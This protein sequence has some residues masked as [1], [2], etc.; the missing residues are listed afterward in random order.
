M[1]KTSSFIA[2]L[3]TI[4][5]LSS[6]FFGTKNVPIIIATPEKALL[7]EPIEI[8]ISNLAAHEQIALEASC[9]DKDNNLWKSS[10]IF[11]ADDKGMVHVAKQAP[12]SGSYK[13]IDPMGLFWSMA[14]TNKDPSKNT[15]ISQSTLSLHKIL[16]SIFSEDKLRA[17]KTIHRLPVSHDVEKKD[18]QEQGIVGTL[19]Y[20]KNTK[21]S[22]GLIIIPGSGGRAP[23]VISQL[24]ASHGYTVLALAYF[25]AEGLPERL[26]LIPLEY[27]QNA[28][29]WFKKQPQVNGNK[30]A[31]MGQSRGAELVLLLASTFPGEMDAVIAYSASHLVYSDF[32]S[33][34]KSAWT[35]KDTPVP[36]MP[37]P[38]N[39]E[40]FEAAKEGHIVLHKGTIEDPFQDTQIFLYA[41]KMKKFNKV[42]KEATIPVENIRCPILILSGDDDKMWPSPVSGNSIIERLDSKGSK[43]KRKHVNY[44]NTG[45]NLFIFPHVPS[46][47]LPVQITSGWSLFGGTP[48]GNAHAHKEAWREVLNFL[49][50]TL[51]K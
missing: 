5:L 43:I 13:S 19:F 22:P 16:L 48:D 49:N 34:Q 46:I 6:I 33:E 10:A 30:I 31:L 36:F 50:E 12:I 4:I 24:L 23:D 45:H 35:Y 39:K 2:L 44:P 26:S 7:D 27:F 3:S 21:R 51:Q 11:Q 28:M 42:V 38:S 17:Q 37:Y 15:F 18:I 9:K 41:M 32:L 25:G 40:I 47:D 14:P 20:P 29:L 8:I 1:T